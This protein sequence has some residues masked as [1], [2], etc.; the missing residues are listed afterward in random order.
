M[1]TK[2]MGNTHSPF[3][4]QFPG[5]WQ[6][7]NWHHLISDS[8]CLQSQ[9]HISYAMHTCWMNEWPTEIHVYFCL[10]TLF[11]SRVPLFVRIWLKGTLSVCGVLWRENNLS[12][13]CKGPIFACSLLYLQFTM[14]LFS[15]TNT[16][17]PLGQEAHIQITVNALQNRSALFFNHSTS[18]DHLPDIVLGTEKSSGDQD[19]MPSL[20]SYWERNNPN[21]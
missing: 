4:T 5:L 16:G 18:L 17:D 1:V 2:G 13:L 12:Y 21:S 9:Q 6:T 11:L 8:L 14:A 15:K 7:E 10:M 3:L 19:N 20:A